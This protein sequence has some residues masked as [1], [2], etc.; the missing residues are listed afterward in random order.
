MAALRLKAVVTADRQ[1]KLDLP[2]D[3]PV[4]VKV[5]LACYTVLVIRLGSC[6]STKN[7]LIGGVY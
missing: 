3:L 4:G 7:P 2:D 1:L 6:L 5:D